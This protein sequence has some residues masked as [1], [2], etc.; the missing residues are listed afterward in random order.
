MRRPSVRVVAELA[1]RTERV[2]EADK[3]ST[4]AMAHLQAL[5][6]LLGELPR[7]MALEL[8]NYLTSFRKALA[9]WLDAE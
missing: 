3:Q 6:P 9:A 5:E 2:P 8:L 1:R 4:L 7:S